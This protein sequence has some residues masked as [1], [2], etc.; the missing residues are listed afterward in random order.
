MPYFT[1]DICKLNCVKK[2]QKSVSL[3]W[4]PLA[5]QYGLVVKLALEMSAV[6]K[7]Q[8]PNTDTAGLGGQ[9]GIDKVDWFDWEDKV[10]WFDWEDKVDWFESTYR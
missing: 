1:V 2:V 5:S 9:S 7:L 6:T 3:S 8:S 4:W 10:D